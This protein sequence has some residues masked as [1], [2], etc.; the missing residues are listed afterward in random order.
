MAVTIAI[1]TMRNACAPG[2][3]LVYDES[4]I[5]SVPAGAS[6]AGV[7][8]ILNFRFEKDDEPK[9]NG[10]TTAMSGF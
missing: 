2:V 8:R 9:S 4:K 7:A 1:A 10:G 5:D 6:L 3:K